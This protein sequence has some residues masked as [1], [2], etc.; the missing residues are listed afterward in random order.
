MNTFTLDRETF[1]GVWADYVEFF[2]PRGRGPEILI[3]HTKLTD[4]VQVATNTLEVDNGSVKLIVQVRAHRAEYFS[5]LRFLESPFN[6]SAC[7]S[8]NNLFGFLHIYGECAV[9]LLQVL[10]FFLD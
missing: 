3:L 7:V 5:R 9:E 2:L 8:S 6:H 10:I 4:L 1:R